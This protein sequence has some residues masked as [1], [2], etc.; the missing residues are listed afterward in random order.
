MPLVDPVSHTGL[1]LLL[2]ADITSRAQ[3]E[4]SMAALTESQLTMLEQM[5]PR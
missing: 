2:Q 4:K 5:F 3:L 1:L